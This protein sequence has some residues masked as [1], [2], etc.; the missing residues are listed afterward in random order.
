M[1]RQIEDHLSTAGDAPLAILAD[2][3]LAYDE[4]RRKTDRLMARFRA[5]GLVPGDRMA[6][7]C[8]DDRRLI[9]LVTAALRAGIAFVVGDP[10]TSRGEAE[11]L[12]AVCRPAAVLTDVADLAATG[13]DAAPPVL[14]VEAWDRDAADGTD[15]TDGPEPTGRPAPPGRHRRPPC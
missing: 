14:R 13:P 2:G 8:A 11:S 1:R 3:P 9:L 7:F 15:E 5:A 4:A 6:L 12:L 10:K